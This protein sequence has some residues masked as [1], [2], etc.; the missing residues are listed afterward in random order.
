MNLHL[1]GRSG[2]LCLWLWLLPLLAA[3]PVLFV[4]AVSSVKTQL[5]RRSTWRHATAL[6]E[7]VSPLSARRR[8]LRRL[9]FDTPAGPVV[10]TTISQ[11]SFLEVG[12]EVPVRYDPD[13]PTNAMIDATYYWVIE[14]LLLFGTFFVLLGFCVLAMTR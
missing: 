6:V 13:R 5:H 14:P 2:D 12:Q 11:P 3:L 8:T 4:K 1:E 10:F 7:A 9:R